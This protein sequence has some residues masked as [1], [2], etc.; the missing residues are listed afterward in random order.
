M[1]FMEVWENSK[2]LWKHSPVSLSAPK[3]FLF[4]PNFNLCF[5]NLIEK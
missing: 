4:L 1:L 3:A 2:K 5:Y